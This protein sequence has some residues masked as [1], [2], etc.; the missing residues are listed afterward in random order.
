MM[1]T[2]FGLADGSAAAAA[3]SCTDNEASSRVTMSAYVC[4]MADISEL[5]LSW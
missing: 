5:K 3:A 1:K 4:F 2:M